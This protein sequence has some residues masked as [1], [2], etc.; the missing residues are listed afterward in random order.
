VREF[1]RA[2]GFPDSFTWD[3]ENQAPKDMYK[4][5]GNAVAIPVG[6]A[7]GRELLKVMITKWEQNVTIN[8]PNEAKPSVEFD[9]D[10]DMS[11][12]SDQLLDSDDENDND[13][14]LAESEDVWMHIDDSDH[15]LDNYMMND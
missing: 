10:V 14:V 1:A 9:D 12:S 13:N 5:I 7:L 11:A 4:Q 15:E 2:M 3:H 6:R 8:D